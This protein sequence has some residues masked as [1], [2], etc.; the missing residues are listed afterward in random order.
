VST[1]SYI[2]I[3]NCGQKGVSCDSTL[4]T[5]EE[6]N[7]NI[8]LTDKHHFQNALVP[9]LSYDNL[10]INN[11]SSASST[12]ANL[13]T[14]SDLDQINQ[15][16]EHLLEYCKLDTFAMVKILEVLRSV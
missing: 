13:H 8:I 1:K 4:N 14:L 15:T 3:N 5:G 11:G 6:S 10:E 2:G 9:S 16:R 7:M 12:Y